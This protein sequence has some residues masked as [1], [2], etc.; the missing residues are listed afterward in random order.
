[1]KELRFPSKYILLTAFSL[2]LIIA[3]FKQGKIGLA[4]YAL[5]GLIPWHILTNA[6]NWYGFIIRYMLLPCKHL[7]AMYA[8]SSPKRK[9]VVSS[10]SLKFTFCIALIA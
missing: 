8:I 3:R 10:H 1:M 2:P 9:L 6:F 4:I 5:L 7:P